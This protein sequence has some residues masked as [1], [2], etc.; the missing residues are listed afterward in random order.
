MWQ[1]SKDH[2]CNQG[3]PRGNPQAQMQQD[4]VPSLNRTRGELG[5]SVSFDWDRDQ[6]K[7]M[8][9]THHAPSRVWLYFARQSVDALAMTGEMD[10]TE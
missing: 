4:S 9:G 1:A 5:G 3:T 10:G 6:Q 8:K 2:H 7:G